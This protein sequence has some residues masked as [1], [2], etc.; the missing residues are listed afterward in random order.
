MS[1]YVEKGIEDGHI[2]KYENA[3]DDHDDIGSSDIVFKFI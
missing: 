2:M 1:V 3:G